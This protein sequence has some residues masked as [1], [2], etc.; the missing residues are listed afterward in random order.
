[1]KKFF[2]YISCLLCISAFAQEKIVIEGA[3]PNLFFTHT[4]AA[5]ETLYGLARVYNQTAAAI[6]TVNGLA[7]DAQL[8]VGQKIKIPIS[9]N[10]FVQNGQKAADETL[11]PLYHIVQ[12]KHT[13]YGISR[14]YNNVRIDFIK[15]WNNMSNDVIK[16]NQYLIVGYLKSKISDVSSNAAVAKVSANSE[17]Q[18]EIP[19]TKKIETPLPA[20][21]VV[22]E[23][24][25]KSEEQKSVPV[26]EQPK[27][28]EEQKTAQVIVQQVT[29]IPQKTESEKIP[30]NTIHVGDKG[31]FASLY[32]KGNNEVSG[33]AAIF[34]TTSGWT[35]GKFYVLMNN[36][37]AG[38]IV[39][40]SANGQVIYAKV[41]GALPDVKEDNGLMMRISTAGVAALGIADTKFFVTVNY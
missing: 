30:V 31:Y 22:K 32:Q 34:K 37:D 41:L 21:V 5:K 6:A 36:A 12:A 20:T 10:N 17:K 23:E 35:D 4:T 16:L 39:R 7:N 3:A 26:K 1:M 19:A 38:S 27:K 24:P 33:D 2:V 18:Y 25:K 28:A 29:A 14:M 9:N 40:V 11:I 13:L 15:E 8:S